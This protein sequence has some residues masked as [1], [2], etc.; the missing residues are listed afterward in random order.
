LNGV[1]SDYTEDV[2]Q[3]TL[4]EAWRHLETLRE[5]ARFQAWLDG[6]CRNVCRRQ[7]RKDD[8]LSLHE[9]RFG[10]LFDPD[11][12]E[13]MDAWL[14]MLDL[15]T[16]DPLEELSQ[17]DLATLLYRAMGHLPA[18]TRQMLE[19]C[20]LAEIPQREVAQRLELT[21]GA[22]ELRLHRARQQLRQ[23]LNGPL[24]PEAQY[25]GVVLDP[26]EAQNWQVMRQWCWFCGK[27]KLLARFEI[28]ADAQKDLCLRCPACS[29]MV[30]HSC[31]HQA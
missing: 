18:H 25:F 9:Q 8:T 29:S 20:Y 28:Q 10:S 17:Q 19:M 2:V 30:R 6:I 16:S 11:A 31:I 13:G 5:P 27:Q 22:L 1:V 7:R 4:V 24:R 23:I 3:E 15:S 12:T 26:E 14:D 21:I